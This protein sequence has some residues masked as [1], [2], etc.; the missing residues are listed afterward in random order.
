VLAQI[1]RDMQDGKAAD[2][3]GTP[4]LFV[5]GKRLMNRSFDGFRQMI[6]ASLGRPPAPPSP[7]G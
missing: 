7:T 5:N 6:D 1:N 2:V 4:T 3:T